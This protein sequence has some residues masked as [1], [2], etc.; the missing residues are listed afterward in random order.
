M[1]YIVKYYLGGRG[2]MPDE[3]FATEDI[4]LNRCQELLDNHGQRATVSIYTD[5]VP[6]TPLRDW[7]WIMKWWREKNH[8]HGFSN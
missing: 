3:T 6:D 4:A 2:P 1:N 7:L 5:S 8:P